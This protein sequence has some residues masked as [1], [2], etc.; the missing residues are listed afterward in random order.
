MNALISALINVRKFARIIHD[1]RLENAVWCPETGRFHP[2]AR[3]NLTVSRNG[4]ILSNLFRLGT[5]TVVS[6]NGT[7]SE[8]SARSASRAAAAVAIRDIRKNGTPSHFWTV[9][10]RNK[11]FGATHTETVRFGFDFVSHRDD[12]IGDE[13]ANIV[14]SD[15]GRTT[16]NLIDNVIFHNASQNEPCPVCGRLNCDSATI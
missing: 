1:I 5:A 3:E 12:S 16:N 10:M 13:R 8:V 15:M 9:T 14:V 2:D 6:E 7:V 4:K 11:K